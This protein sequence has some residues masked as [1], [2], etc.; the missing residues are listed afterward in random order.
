MRWRPSKKRP[1][2]GGERRSIDA[3]SHSAVWSSSAIFVEEDDAQNG[4]TSPMRTL[5]INTPPPANF[6]PWTHVPAAVALN[7][8]VTQT[9][10]QSIP[11]C[12]GTP[13]LKA[14]TIPAGSPAVKAL[15]AGW[16]K[17][18]AE[19]YGGKQIRPF[20]GEKTVRPASE[21][22]KAAPAKNDDD[23]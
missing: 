14:Q 1:V 2:S 4:V 5:F 19:I 23:N 20:P 6:L 7:T 13:A 21:F 16:M 3:I 8:G 17:K 22:N 15:R 18:R 12:P 9:P 11:T 10:T